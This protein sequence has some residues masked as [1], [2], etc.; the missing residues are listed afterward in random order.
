MNSNRFVGYIIKLVVVVSLIFNQYQPTQVR[1]AGASLYFTPSV[2]TYVLD[3]KFTIAVKAFV[4][5]TNINAAEGLISFDKNFLE[6]VSI[7]DTGSIFSLWPIQ[8]SFSNSQGTVSFAGG[9]Q[10]PGYS[11]QQGKVLNITFKAKAVGIG[12]VRFS[13]G[14]ILS[15]DGKASNILESMGSANF[16]IAAKEVVNTPDQAVKASEDF[17]DKKNSTTAIIEPMDKLS[18]SVGGDDYLK[19]YITSTTNV[20]QNTWTNNNNVQVQWEVPQNVSGLSWSITHDLKSEPESKPQGLVSNKSFE[21]L[22]DGIWFFHLKFYDGKRWGTTSHFRVL[23]DTVRPQPLVITVRQVD[24]SSFP[25]LTFKTTDTTS[26]VEHYEVFV[27]SLENKEFSL[28]EDQALTQQDVQ[29]ANLEYG[30]HTA[31]VKAIDRAGNEA[32]ATV[33]FE[34]QPIESPKINN[35]AKEIKVAD[36]F[37]VSGSGLSDVNVNV[38][39]QNEENKVT[40]AVV[41]S[42]QNG[43]WFYLGDSKLKNGRYV[44]WVE[45][46]NLAGLK[47]MPS[48]KVS[49][50]VTPPVFA[51]IGNFVINY[52]TVLVSLLFMVLLISVVLFYII[53]TIRKRL[54]KETTEVEVVLQQNLSNLKKIIEDEVA[55]LNKLSPSPAVVKEGKVMKDSFNKQIEQARKKIMKEIKDVEDVLR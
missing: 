27:N 20:D 26:G 16:T 22:S 38:Y 6:V 46:E 44:V 54:K 47:S 8:P 1:A 52:F 43:N 45:A 14:A 32:V 15:N 53:S 48:E 42:D 9:V 19:P 11:G 35:Y 36:Q 28:P 51:I 41:H 12:L 23:I 5:G 50:L 10:A 55:K 13:S 40:S 34:V 33:E 2:G 29:L 39:I 18:Q 25:R 21:N 4:G 7:S 17:L 24:A 30:K 31:L 3:D 37:F 49:F